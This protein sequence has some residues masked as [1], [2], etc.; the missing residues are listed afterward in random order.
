LC[1][2]C[3]ERAGKHSYYGGQVCPSCRAFFRRSVHPSVED[4][5]PNPDP[6]PRIHMVLGLLDPDPKPLVGSE[7]ISQRYGSSG[8]GSFYHL[9]KK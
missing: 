3:G 5:D 2:V 8:S 1:E 9:A 7:T 4:P 6:D